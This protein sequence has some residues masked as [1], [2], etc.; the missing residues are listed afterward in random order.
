M[1]TPTPQPM[2]A[3]H[4]PAMSAADAHALPATVPPSMSGLL[5]IPD[6]STWRICAVC[7][8]RKPLSQFRRMARDSDKR[9]YQC[10]DCHS[11]R[12]RARRKRQR[13]KRRGQA[14]D[15]FAKSAVLTQNPRRLVATGEAALRRFGGM[16]KLASLLYE[17]FHKVEAGSTKQLLL[18][19]SV[20]RMNAFDQELRAT[21]ADDEYSKYVTDED[22]ERNLRHAVADFIRDCP[23]VAISAAEEAGWTIIPP[24]GQQ[25]RR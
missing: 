12:E 7:G 20:M 21:K 9:G 5:P 6:T 3:A 22:I 4:A 11:E 1:S 16:D 24:G 17:R 25:D 18:G 2:T 23:A 13:A 10:N 14:V 15:R 8:N 19:L